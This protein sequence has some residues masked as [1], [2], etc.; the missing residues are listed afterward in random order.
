MH[1]GRPQT[2][3]TEA[4]PRPRRRAHRLACRRR[5][6]ALRRCRALNARSLPRV[7]CGTSGGPGQLV[8]CTSGRAPA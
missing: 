5:E 6:G 3:G 2:N 4:A 7:L 1:R 8:R